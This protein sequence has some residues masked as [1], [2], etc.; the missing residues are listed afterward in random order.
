MRIKVKRESL[1]KVLDSAVEV[2]ES[3]NTLPVLQHVLFSANG[4]LMVSATDLELSF[5]HTT[6]AEIEKPGSICLPA[7]KLLQIVKEL[8]EEDVV[9]EEEKNS[10]IKILCGRGEFHLL[11][12]PEE[13][14]PQPQLEV[15]PQG[16]VNSK[17]FIQALRL[18]VFAVSDD[19]YRRNLNGVYIGKGE[20]AGTDG[21]RLSRVIVHELTLP[22]GV[23]IPKKGA[24]S[25]IKLFDDEEELLWTRDKNHLIISSEEKTLAVRLIEGEFP[26]YSSVTN[27]SGTTLYLSLSSLKKELEL[28][29]AVGSQWIKIVGRGKELEILASSRMDDSQMQS[30]L[31]TLEGSW[32]G[33]IGFD[34]R[35][36][37]EP[38][39]LGKENWTVELLITGSDSPCSLKFS[40]SPSFQYVVMPMRI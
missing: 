40:E 24:V 15:K 11:G 37:L 23:I 25:L 38:L 34:T 20:I 35:Y 13:D 9:L 2:A 12:L 22:E 4:T 14:F 30:T 5:T 16:Q 7:R 19:E 28:A 39:K 6:P 36:L 8:P 18:T 31:T 27:I 17:D 26:N 3:K 10:R 1:K 32:E 33:E 21:H 29:R